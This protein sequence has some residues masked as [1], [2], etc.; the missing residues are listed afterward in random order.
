MPQMM[1]YDLHKCHCCGC[2]QPCHTDTLLTNILQPHPQHLVN[3]H[4]KAWHCRCWGL[5]KD[6]QFFADTKPTHIAEFKRFHDGEH[7]KDFF[8]DSQP[9]ALPLTLTLIDFYSE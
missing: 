2:V 7:P 6:S 8:N 1:L 3:K 4:H 5:C 9:N